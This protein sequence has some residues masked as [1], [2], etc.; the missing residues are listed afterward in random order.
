[1]FVYDMIDRSEGIDV[2]KTKKSRRFII[3]NYYYF[4]K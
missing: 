4:L 3:C 1:M 2:N